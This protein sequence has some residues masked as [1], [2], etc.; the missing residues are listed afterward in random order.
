MFSVF[1]N[2]ALKSPPA[3]QRARVTP[4]HLYRLLSAEFREHRPSRCAC[5]M[6]MVTFREPGRPGSANWQLEL[7]RDCEA[8]KP[9]VGQ[10]V[11]RFA[12]LYDIHNP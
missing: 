1:G 11:S 5:R 3:V 2:L 9:L 8:C 12:Q 6:P 7:R 4:G 10:L